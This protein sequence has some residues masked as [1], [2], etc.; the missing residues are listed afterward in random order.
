VAG[1]WFDVFPLSEVFGG[2][3]FDLEAPEP[4]EEDGNRT[5]IGV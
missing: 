3:G 4:V 5:E 2:F 1:E